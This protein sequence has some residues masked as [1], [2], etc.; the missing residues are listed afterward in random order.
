M[1]L[2]TTTT[3]LAALGVTVVLAA[4]ASAQNNA[5]TPVGAKQPKIEVAP[6]DFDF[7]R[8]PQGASIAHAFWIKNVGEDTLRIADVKP[9]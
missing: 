9:G 7:G 3:L 5:A 4:G 8:V 6:A 2:K 1:R